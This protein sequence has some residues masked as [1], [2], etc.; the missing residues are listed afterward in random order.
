LLFYTKV[1]GEDPAFIHPDAKDLFYGNIQIKDWLES[2]TKQY[3]KD[4]HDAISTEVRN[5]NLA[6]M[7]ILHRPLQSY[8]WL[9]S[10]FN[11]LPSLFASVVVVACF[12]V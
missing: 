5:V 6:E 12:F 2:V 3:S 1:T 11:G 9:V 10:C 4:E 7:M 8:P